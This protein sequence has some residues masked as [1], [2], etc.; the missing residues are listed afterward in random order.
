MSFGTGHHATTC[1]M[2]EAM[3]TIPFLGKSVIDFG[4][5]T[6]ILAILAEK[7]GA[8]SIL[9][10]DNDQWSINNCRDNIA[11]NNCRPGVISLQ[12][13][14]TFPVNSRFQ[15]ILANINLNII[16]A[17]LEQ[18]L[19]SAGD[20]GIILLS[21]LLEADETIIKDNLPPQL[22]CTIHTYKKNGWIL[23]KILTHSKTNGKPVSAV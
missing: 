9:A 19:F 2:A 5:G 1:L 7:L 23:I 22:V 17:N 18:M 21:G 10:I 16:L 12:L 8:A 14:N 13:A 11:E 20:N 4:T 15:I 6:G 3:A